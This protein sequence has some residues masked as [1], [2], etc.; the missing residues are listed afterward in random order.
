MKKVTISAAVLALALMGCSDA[1]LDNSVASTNEV[2]NE[3]SFLAKGGDAPVNASLTPGFWHGNNNGYEQYNYSAW[4]IRVEMQSHAV[5]RHGVGEYH[6]MNGPTPDVIHVVTSAVAGCHV[7]SGEIYCNYD[8]SK[9]SHS[10][11]SNQA[12]AVTADL[13]G[14]N[15]SDITVVTAFAAVWNLG[16]PQEIVL[17]AATYNGIGPLTLND[18]QKV[19]EKY[20]I[21]A[22]HNE[23]NG[24]N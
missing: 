8:K 4:N 24:N 5:G 19:Y 2:N 20:V 3:S 14:V 22:A 23:M 16:T 11:G 9:V 15:T 21:Q 6:V 10:F 1:G 12:V 7:Y 18:A 13:S 17:T